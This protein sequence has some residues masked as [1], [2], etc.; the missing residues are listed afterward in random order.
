[1]RDLVKKKNFHYSTED[2]TNSSI[3][4][5]LVT[6]GRNGNAAGE[7]KNRSIRPAISWHNGLQEKC[8]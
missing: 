6:S 4:V 1:M 5:G 2:Y 8:S 3:L 7:E